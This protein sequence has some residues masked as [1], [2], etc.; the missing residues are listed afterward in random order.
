MRQKKVMIMALSCMLCVGV[1]CTARSA[2][3]ET[4]KSGR[5]Q[6]KKMLRA[7]EIAETEEDALQQTEWK[8]NTEA[9]E[10]TEQ[11]E[12]AEKRE[13]KIRIVKCKCTKYGQLTLKFARKVIL[14][15][16]VSITIDDQNG[17]SYDVAIVDVS[18]KRCTVQTSSDLVKDTK[19]IIS[20]SGVKYVNAEEYTKAVKK[21]TYK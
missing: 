2:S 6:E 14:S 11:S 4:Q 18:G 5:V 19:Y 15:E 17:N 12:F 13:K 8:E 7:S 10:S 1:F 9:P 16:D 3:A 20:I 21:F